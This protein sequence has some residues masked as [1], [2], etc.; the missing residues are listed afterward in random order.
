MS[1]LDLAELERPAKA[2]PEDLPLRSTLYVTLV[3]MGPAS[4]KALRLAAFHKDPAVMLV[5][6]N[7]R[8]AFKVAKSWRC[9]EGFPFTSSIYISVYK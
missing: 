1:D 9:F 2:N 6:G 7:K 4:E 8:Q 5:V 3:S